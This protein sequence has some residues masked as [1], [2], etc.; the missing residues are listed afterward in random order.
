[1]PL[2]QNRGGLFYNRQKS[3][4]M[5]SPT[6]PT[7]P[8]FLDQTDVIDFLPTFVT[9]TTLRSVL[10]KIGADKLEDLE[11]HSSASRSNEPIGG[12]TK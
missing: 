4:S 1:M 12:G 6:S 5:K 3:R 2:Q 10:Q 8:R 9:R 7:E 11:T